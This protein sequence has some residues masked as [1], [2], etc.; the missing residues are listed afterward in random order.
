MICEQVAWYRP[1]GSNYVELYVA[2]DLAKWCV[3]V[4]NEIMYYQEHYGEMIL[5]AWIDIADNVFRYLV[6]LKRDVII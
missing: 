1:L 3:H 6:N 2:T 5:V 4:K